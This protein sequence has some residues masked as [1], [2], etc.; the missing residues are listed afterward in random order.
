MTVNIPEDV[1]FDLLSSLL[2]GSN[3]DSPTP[4]TIIS[5]YRIVVAQASDIDVAFKELE[6]TKAEVQ[7]KEVELDQALQDRETVSKELETVSES[8]QTELRQVKQEKDDIGT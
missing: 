2:P 7:R 6:E 1:D 5:L 3:F 4:E 8:F